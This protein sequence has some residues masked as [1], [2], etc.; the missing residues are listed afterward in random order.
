MLYLQDNLRD[1]VDLIRIDVSRLY[2]LNHR[3][4]GEPR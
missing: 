1:S 4:K 3:S 2:E